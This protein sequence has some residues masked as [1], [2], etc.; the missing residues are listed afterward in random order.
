MARRYAC[1]AMLIA[2]IALVSPAR[3][4]TPLPQVMAA[5]AD[6]TRPAADAARDADRKPAQVIA[7]SGMKPGDK[8][9][10]LIPG[11]GYYTRIFAKVVGAQGHV[12][13]A[14]PLIMASRPGAL[15]GLN[16]IAAA[17]PN[18][19]ATAVDFATMRFPE[20]LDLIWTS[21][22]Y[23]DFHNIPNMDVVALNRVI[24]A[25]LKPGGVYIVEDHSAPGAGL[26]V[27]STLHRIDPDAVVREVEAAGFVLDG[28]STALANPADPHTA[29]VRDPSI[30]GKTDKFVLKFRKPG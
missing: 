15:D 1:G 30:R 11:G 4:Q 9:A 14:V 2:A 10:D 5:V 24:F 7:F 29:G 25:A 8:I 26:A 19:T 16:A 12:Y 22:N 20:Q 28:R 3:A 17:N 13:A 23:H 21:E 6:A 18:V 27:T